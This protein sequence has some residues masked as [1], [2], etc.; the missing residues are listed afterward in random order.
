MWGLCDGHM[1][2]K[3]EIALI[4]MGLC[5]SMIR[6]TGLFPVLLTGLFPVLI[7]KLTCPGI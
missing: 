4:N 6:L 2:T 3:I 5:V 7:K 1:W